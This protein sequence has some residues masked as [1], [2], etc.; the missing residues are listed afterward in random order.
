MELA[1]R[2]EKI[3]FAGKVFTILSD[4][5]T[6]SGLW[7]YCLFNAGD[8]EEVHTRRLVAP[9]WFCSLYDSLD[10]YRSTLS[11]CRELAVENEFFRIVTW[12]N[13][14]ED[15]FIA[16]TDLLSSF[17]QGEQFFLNEVR[18]TVVHGWLNRRNQH[19]FTVK[20]VD[21][22][23]ILKRRK[24]TKKENTTLTLPFYES[25][26]GLSVDKL[27]ERFLDDTNDTWL[28]INFL[29]KHQKLFHREI[30]EDIGVS[31]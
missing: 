15:L 18:L 10:A 20:Y 21:R 9:I 27:S 30:Y 11:E 6:C 7:R 2:E 8:N 25:G 19:K 12:C 26:W 24:I 4:C 1:S 3:I 23:G 14:A 13:A 5:T 29:I 28:H 17:T 22:H 16:I 31:V